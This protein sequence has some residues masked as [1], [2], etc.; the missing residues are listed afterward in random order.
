MLNPDEC[1]CI[2]ACIQA[3]ILADLKPDKK[4]E[5]IDILPFA[6]GTDTSGDNW[7]VIIEKNSQIPCSGTKSYMTSRDNQEFLNIDVL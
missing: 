5:F 7:S 2:G 6:F 3:S 4:I 1:V